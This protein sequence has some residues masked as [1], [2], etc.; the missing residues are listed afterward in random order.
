MNN[1]PKDRY[2]KKL[3]RFLK[4]YDNLWDKCKDSNGIVSL[5]KWEEARQNLEKEFG[6]TET[7]LQRAYALKDY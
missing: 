6:M 3:A 4:A 5:I 2:E 1:T 7:D